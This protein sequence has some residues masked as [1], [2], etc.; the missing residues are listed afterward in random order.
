MQIY[1]NVLSTRTGKSF[2][3]QIEEKKYA[4]NIFEGFQRYCIEQQFSM[5]SVAAVFLPSKFCIPGLIG[6]Y[7]TMG[8]TEKSNLIVVAQFDVDMDAIHS[9][10]TKQN[11]QLQFQNEYSDKYITVTQINEVNYQIKVNRIN[12]T[13]Y[14]QRVPVEIPKKFYKELAK[15]NK[16][17]FNGTEFDGTE[18]CDSPIFLDG[19]CLVFSYNNFES[20]IEQATESKV[21]IC[22]NIVAAK[23]L[24]D[25]FKNLTDYTIYYASGNKTVEFRDFY[26]A[27][28]NL[29][30]INKSFLLQTIGK[31][32]NVNSEDILNSLDADD[33][34]FNSQLNCNILYSGDSMTYEKVN[35]FILNR[36][37][38]PGYLP[39]TNIPLSHSLTFLGTG[40]CVPSKLR[41]VSSILLETSNSCMLMDCGEDT[42][43]QILRLYGN[44]NILNKLSLIYLSH[45][46]ADHILGTMAIIRHL[47]HPITVVAPIRCLGLIRSFG[48]LIDENNCDNCNDG[49]FH[50]FISTQDAKSLEYLFYNHFSNDIIERSW[51]SEGHGFIDSISKYTLKYSFEHF[52]LEI[53]GCYHNVDSTSVVVTCQDNGYRVSYSGDTSPSILFSDMS[54]NVDLMIHEAS[55]TDCQMKYAIKTRHSTEME[56][57][58]VSKR[59][60]A[61]K[62]LMTHFSNRNAVISEDLGQA[63]DFYRVELN[64]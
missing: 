21:F 58:E 57:L 15:G 43:G 29:N 40:C 50:K 35:G 19:I 23:Y 62:L 55:F 24:S 6:A 36:T 3:L 5:C 22:M 28:N 9:C 34:I 46:H 12:G 26:G 53:C 7:L 31:A 56:A 1:Y 61:K 17:T 2:I 4:F 64:K 44:L 48:I 59:A 20:L 47:K 41:N 30:A 11:I 18:Y 39:N 38:V 52:C 49:V 8:S 13:F 14:P 63:T 27:Q 51:I 32:G 60:C 54:K 45:S 25:K 42:I 16:I 37:K 33:E 10:C